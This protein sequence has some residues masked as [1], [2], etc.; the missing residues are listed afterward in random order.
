M[1]I[2]VVEYIGTI[3]D[4][5]AETLVKDYALLLDK[6]KFDVVVLCEDYEKNSAN[7]K[8]I[9]NSGINI[10]ATYDPCFILNK[11][12]Y[13]LFGVKYRARLLRKKLIELKPDVLHIHLEELEDVSL[14]ADILKDTKLVYTCHNLPS[15]MIGEER[16]KEQKAC[17]YLLENNNL[18]I[19]ALHD[20][21]ADEINKRFNIN[22]TKVIRNGID[23]NRF[24]NLR[25]TREE[26]RKELNISEDTYL[27]GHVG[28]FTYQKNHEF[29]IN[30]FDL[31]LKKNPNSHLLLVGEGKLK[32][33]VERQL[34]ELNIADKVT[35]LSNRNDVAELM[36][37][38]D[39]FV[40]PSRW[41]GLGIV[42]IEAQV[43]KL[44][45][46]VSNNVPS[47][48]FQSEYITSLSL[49]EDFDTWANYVLN[50]VCNINKEFKLEEYDMNNEILKLQEIYLKRDS[51]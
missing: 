22:N 31:T 45:C 46:V 18:Q 6:E 35:I 47:E 12:M 37:T 3:K 50:P 13:R 21:M 11:I 24:Y 25:K 33:D 51:I 28:R 5:G 20:E 48:A 10:I 14:N 41:E 16:P 15:R 49:E 39:V 44:N 19:V 1:K 42:L 26:I 4:A 7:Y 43:S 38:M 36:N 27:I 17:K 23:F 32:K 8:T 2:K 29:L 30:V 40:F 34:L 9:K